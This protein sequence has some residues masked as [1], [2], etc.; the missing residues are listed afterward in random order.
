[1]ITLFYIKLISLLL[2]IL[3]QTTCNEIKR[4][5]N[6]ATSKQPC[7]K[8]RLVR[9]PSKQVLACCSIKF[10]NYKPFSNPVHVRY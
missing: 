2:I 6:E 8:R 9:I 10:D 4:M 1:M 7:I 5:L 3:K